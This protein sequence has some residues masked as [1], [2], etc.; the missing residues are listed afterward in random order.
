MMHLIL[1]H[2]RALVMSCY[3]E[4]YKPDYHRKALV[5]ANPNIEKS[6]EMVPQF[7][8]YWRNNEYESDSLLTVEIDSE[9]LLPSAV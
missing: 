2:R 6:C 5:K 4:S 1:D 9:G 3:M 7:R 8:S